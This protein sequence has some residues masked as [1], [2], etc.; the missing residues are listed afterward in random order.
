[1]LIGRQPGLAAGRI[2]KRNPVAT[3][4]NSEKGAS[5]EGGD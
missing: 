5:K 4:V 1:L 3:G 2:K